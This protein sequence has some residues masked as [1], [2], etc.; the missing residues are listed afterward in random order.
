[1]HYTVSLTEQLIQET[2]HALIR[3]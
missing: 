2:R 1:M 3:S